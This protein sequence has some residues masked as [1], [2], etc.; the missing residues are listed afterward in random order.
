MSKVLTSVEICAGAGGQ[1]L[2]LESAGFEHR[3]VVEIDAKAV[4][5]LRI[6]RPEWNVI[7]GDVL[8]FDIDPYS[9]ELDLL[10]GGV[11]CPPFSIAGKQLGRDDERD[12]FPRALELTEAARP[13]AVM[14]ENVRGLSQ[15]RFSAYRSE[16]IAAFEELGYTVFWETVI[17]ADFGLPQLRPRFV[18]VALLDPYAQYFS[19]PEPYEQSMTVG[20]VLH[21]FMAEAGW[22]GAAEWAKNANSVGPTLVGGSKKHGGPDLGPTRA[23]E[24]WRKLGVKGSSIADLPPGPDF[25]TDPNIE[26]PRLTVRMGAALQGFPPEWKWTGGKTAAWKQV[27]NAFPP[28]VAAAIGR[29]IASAL[30]EVPLSAPFTKAVPSIPDLTLIES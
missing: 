24:S 2:G 1:A 4:E 23:R 22:S 28:P 15:P 6:N 26:M 18:L 12:L 30:R 13:R 21:P 8:E 11:P 14:L 3:A 5:T 27:G 7:H 25:P 29:R 10:A 9:A 19:W 17:S 16:L 20:E